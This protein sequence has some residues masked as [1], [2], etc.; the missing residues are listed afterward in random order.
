MERFYDEYDRNKLE[1]A[2]KI[3]TEVY[4]STYGALRSSKETKKLETIIRKLDSILQETTGGK[5]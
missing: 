1:R 3:I 4:E 5:E 2:K